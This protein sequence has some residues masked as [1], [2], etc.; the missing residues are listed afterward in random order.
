MQIFHE[1]A[2]RFGAEYLT[3]KASRVDLSHRP[4]AV[5]VGDPQPDEPAYEADALRSSPPAPSR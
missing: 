1:Q 2:A 3:A 5:W 4:F